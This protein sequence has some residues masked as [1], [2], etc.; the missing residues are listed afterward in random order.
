MMVHSAE[1]LRRAHSVHRS[2]LKQ[3]PLPQMCSRKILR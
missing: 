3:M 2:R 1:R